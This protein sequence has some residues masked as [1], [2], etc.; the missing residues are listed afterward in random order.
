MY[1]QI[2]GIFL[3]LTLLLFNIP[4]ARAD[5]VIADITIDELDGPDAGACASPTIGDYDDNGGALDDI[6]LRE[7][8]CWANAN[9]GIDTISLTAGI[10]ILSTANIN[11]DDT[12]SICNNNACDN[13]QG[14]LDIREDLII[15]GAGQGIT[16]VDA[17]DTDRIFHIN[18]AG[19]D[20]IDVT[21][22]DMTVQDGTARE[23]STLDG[24]GGCIFLDEGRHLT[25]TS[26]TVDSCETIPGDSGGGVQASGVG[27]L[28][29][30]DSIFSNN[31][32][33]GGIHTEMDVVIT[34]STIRNNTTTGT[35]DGAGL[36]FND[37]AI[38][39]NVTISNNTSGDEGGG[40]DSG[41]AP[42]EIIML[43]NVTISGNTAADH[44]GGILLDSTGT[45][46]LN[47]TTVTLNETVNGNGG[48]I[49]QEAGTVNIQNSIVQGNNDQVLAANDDCSGTVT[50]QG[51][52]VVGV[53]TGCPSGGTNDTTGAAD[54]AVLADN[55]GDTLTHNLGAGSSAR[56][57][58]PDG[59]AGCTAG[60]TVDQRGA[61]RA[62]ND[63]PNRGGT[64]CDSGAVEADSAQTP[65]AV[66]LQS[67]SANNNMVILPILIAT[68]LLALMGGVILRRRA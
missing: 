31:I 18:D 4:E 59:S 16:I 65:T 61:V 44:G 30:Q 33:G 13:T 23:L 50:S 3:L 9:S 29:I 56:E 52:N 1:K 48:G 38:L 51:G 21:I 24:W 42:G 32:G 12:N 35:Q 45:I 36:R 37:G 57:R 66:S 7:A 49:R 28:T 8:I 60:V 11:E 63:P 54:L 40:I 15:N 55:G 43:T 47:F 20:T 17:N 25:L 27:T 2:I 67:F 19:T 62:D 5:S 14:D 58:I 22:T 53:G 34:N 41:S 10:Y 64:N 39:T 6:S 26:V 68:L 46:N